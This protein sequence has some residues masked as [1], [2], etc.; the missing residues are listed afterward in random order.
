[1][2]GRCGCCRAARC[3]PFG[4]TVVLAVGARKAVFVISVESSVRDSI[5]FVFIFLSVFVVKIVKQ[6][7]LLLIKFCVILVIAIFEGFLFFD[8]FSKLPDY[9]LFLQSVLDGEST[10]MAGRLLY[11]CIFN[12]LVGSKL[13]ESSGFEL[14]IIAIL[15]VF[16]SVRDRHRLAET[17]R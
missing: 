13:V 3:P 17:F 10:T 7:I 6:V 16:A 1:M 4:V 9:V 15:G 2:V 12:L 11:P 14:G 8:L 5:F